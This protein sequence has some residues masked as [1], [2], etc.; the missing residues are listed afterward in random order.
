MKPCTK[1]FLITATLL[2]LAG[3]LLV[4]YED[5]DSPMRGAARAR[6]SQVRQEE[7]CEST[8]ALTQ[9]ILER[10]PRCLVLG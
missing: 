1:V 9:A 6:S 8:E 4:F 2:L 10:Y 3:L 7:D 5:Q